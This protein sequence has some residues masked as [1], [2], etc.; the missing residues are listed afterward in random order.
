MAKNLKAKKSKLNISNIIDIALNIVILGVL[1]AIIVLLVKCQKKNTELFSPH[2]PVTKYACSGEKEDPN[3]RN[4][5][6]CHQSNFVMP[7]THEPRLVATNPI[8]KCN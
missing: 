5:T 8:H 4:N 3:W 6:M 7:D 2:D 1:I